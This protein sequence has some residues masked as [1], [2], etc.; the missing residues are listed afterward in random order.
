MV[1]F[2]NIELIIIARE[3]VNAIIKSE[4]EKEKN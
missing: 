4:R 1:C 3:I 2:K